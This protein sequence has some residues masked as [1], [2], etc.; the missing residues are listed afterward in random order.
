MH[1]RKASPD[2]TLQQLFADSILNE[3]L[4]AYKIG[5]STPKQYL[6]HVRNGIVVDD[7]TKAFDEVVKIIS[8]TGRLTR[9]ECSS[10][11]RNSLIFALAK[12]TNV[13]PSRR[14]MAHLGFHR[15]EVSALLAP[16]ADLLVL[17][18]GLDILFASRRL[19]LS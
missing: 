6:K 5:L 3:C 4:D 18:G 11:V 16:S 17:C 7:P 10:D 8:D 2:D 9:S 14:P 1:E 12:A 19:Q 15:P 13:K